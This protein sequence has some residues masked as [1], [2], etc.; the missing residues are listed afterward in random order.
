[1]SFAVASVIV[2]ALVGL[3]MVR[4]VDGPLDPP[5]FE[6][7]T[8]GGARTDR[9]Q[10]FVVAKVENT[11]DETAEN[12]E[13]V[14]ELTLDGELVEEGQQMIDFLSGGEVEEITFVFVEDPRRGHVD[15]RVVSYGVP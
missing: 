6:V 10:H 9:G 3:L 7:L 4:W 12:V 14:A 1:V 2:L 8:D 5:A 15:V 11:G 13:V